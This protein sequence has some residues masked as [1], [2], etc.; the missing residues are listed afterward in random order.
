MIKQAIKIL[1]DKIKLI[2]AIGLIFGLSLFLRVNFIVPSL[3][4]C[5]LLY[6]KFRQKYPS[7]PVFKLLN[8]A[9]LYVIVFVSSYYVAKNGW[10]IFYVPF[11]VIPMLAAITF[12]NLE[13]PFLL[14]AA[15]GLT[16]ASIYGNNLNL[17][18]MFLI[19]GSVSAMTVVH[20]RKR[21]VVIRSGVLMG[22]IQAL[23]L[24]FVTNFNFY[25]PYRYLLAFLNGVAC[26]VIVIGILPVFEYLFR[27][28]TNISLLELADFNHPLLQR[29]IMEA[30]GTYH[31]SLVVGNLAEAACRPIGA[32]ALLARI[33][34]YYH[35]IGKLDKSGYFIENQD[36]PLNKHDALSPSMSKIVIMN[37]VK[38]GVELANKYH[39]NPK[40]IEFIAQHHGNS[41]V[42]YF[43]RRALENLEEEQDVQE[44][45]FRYPGP[46]PSSKETAVVLLADSV[47]AATRSLKEP[48]PSKVEEVV[49]KVINN[50]FIDGQLDECDLTLRDLE[51]IS[52]IFIRIL[53]G[54]YHSRIIYP[55]STKSENN[56]KKSSKENPHQQ[57]D[58][59]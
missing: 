37:H 8:V 24:L 32:N 39:L 1:I 26:G 25:Y 20:A 43:Y 42:Y 51:K 36:V 18:L 2:L 41:L 33:G 19:S 27:T 22:I 3:L 12:G 47:E 58:Q 16:I 53:S 44:E 34:A 38:E 29:L 15:C 11:C 59:A 13:L 4:L 55:E 54:I 57:S 23:L 31:H 17:G 21:S 7:S 35:D 50:K 30:P 14:S 40:L 10:P 56:H 5:L 48:S 6:I 52:A 49:H 45:G 9:F 28:V 46:K